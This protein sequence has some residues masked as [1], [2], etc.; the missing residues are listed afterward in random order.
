[1]SEFTS[2]RSPV[3]SDDQFL[4]R[5]ARGLGAPT[6]ERADLPAGRRGQRDLD[7]LRRFGGVVEELG[8]ELDRSAGPKVFDAPADVRPI[9]HRPVTQE[10]ISESPGCLRGFGGRPRCVGT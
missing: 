6:T 5:D 10:A 9:E 8:R 3:R 4:E 2:L 1:M 7:G